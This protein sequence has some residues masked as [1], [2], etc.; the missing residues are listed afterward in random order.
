M[1]QS[2]FR[3]T[4]SLAGWAVIRVSHPVDERFVRGE[5]IDDVSAFLVGHGVSSS[6]ATSPTKN[7]YQSHRRSA[8]T[9][10][11]QHSWPR[12]RSRNSCGSAVVVPRYSTISPFAYHSD[13][14]RP[15]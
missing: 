10:Y 8:S 12:P 6:S 5:E 7:R 13:V 9:Q 4:R 11:A 3:R 2:D 1:R 15:W 14:M